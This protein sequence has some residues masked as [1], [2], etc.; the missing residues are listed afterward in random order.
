VTGYLI[1][2]DRDEFPLSD[3]DHAV[4]AAHGLEI[5]TMAG[6]AADDFRR[7][8]DDALGILVWSGRYGDEILDA[9]PHLRVVARCGAGYD[10]IDLAAAHARGLVVT[11]CPGLFD[12]SVAE[13]AIAAIFA[14]GRKLLP[15][16]SAVRRGE[17]PSAA[18]LAPITRLEGM[19]LGLV[20]LGRIAR[21]VLDHATGLGMRAHAYDPYLA[22]SDFP[23]GVARAAALDD[24]LRESDVVSLHVPLN[25][26]TRHLIGARELV[27]MKPTAFLINT[28][29]GGLVD[30]EALAAALE[31]GVIAGA[32]LDV[33]D[34]E[35]I[36]AD[37][38]ILRAPNTLLTPHSSAYDVDA[39]AAVRRQA[40]EDAI[41]VI[42]GRTPRHPID[43]E[44]AIA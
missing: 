28:G 11:F 5:R 3:D 35:P 38:P 16:D 10:N 32:A 41:A 12:A 31:E 37:H 1:A 29:R 39:I 14:L 36:P 8:G 20:G 15:S 22:E 18:E 19:R 4:A 21:R 42:E 27:A 6:H 17:W 33:F 26:E 30:G 2:P 9:L 34:P 23:A 24:L 13:H 44:A 43:L 40:I 7:I 25:D